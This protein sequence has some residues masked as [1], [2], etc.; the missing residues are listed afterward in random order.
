[1]NHTDTPRLSKRSTREGLKPFKKL[2]TRR[3]FQ[4]RRLCKDIDA[5][6]AGSHYGSRKDMLFRRKGLGNN[7]DTLRLSELRKQVA[8]LSLF[9]NVIAEMSVRP[10]FQI[11]SLEDGKNIHAGAIVGIGVGCMANH[12]QGSI[13]YGGK[14]S[15]AAI[16]KTARRTRNMEGAVFL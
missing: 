16:I 8:S 7:L 10:P 5:G 13:G 2:P 1:M 9:V 12:K 14:S 15:N 3:D 11:L 4:N 6:S